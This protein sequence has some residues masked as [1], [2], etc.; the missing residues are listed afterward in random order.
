MPP[1]DPVSYCMDSLM[2]SGAEIL[3]FGGMALVWA[4]SWPIIKAV[5]D[6][7]NDLLPLRA[8]LAVHLAAFVLTACFAMLPIAY[9]LDGTRWWM[10]A[11][12]F[13]LIGPVGGGIGKYHL[14]RKG[15]TAAIWLSAV[16]SLPLLVQTL[17]IGA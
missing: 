4:F 12:A 2:T 5:Y 13:F 16:L 10:A 11:M 17:G 9:F 6:G 3:M 7:R 8:T 15:N 1:C 14:Y